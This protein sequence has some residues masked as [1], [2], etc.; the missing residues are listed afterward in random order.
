[1]V[2]KLLLFEKP[3]RKLFVAAFLLLVSSNLRAQSLSPGIVGKNF[4]A[5]NASNSDSSSQWYETVFTMK[6]LKE[7]K[8]PDGS[9]N[10]RIIGNENIM[11]EII[12]LQNSKVL[13]DC[14]LK[15]GEAHLLR[16][17]FKTGFFVKDIA[18]AEAYFKNRGIG[19]K[20]GPFDDTE[21]AT[22]SFIIEDLQGNALQFI[23]QKSSK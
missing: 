11:V 2:T 6:L 12:Q 17:Y 18:K 21:T 5:I 8:Q 16:G 4:F 13:S 14:S 22:R 10:V 9:V 15:K 1:M 19:I 3:M 20:H 7:I 23:E